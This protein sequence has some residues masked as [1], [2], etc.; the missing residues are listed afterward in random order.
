MRVGALLIALALASGCGPTV[1]ETKRPVQFQADAKPSLFF[2]LAEGTAWSYDVTDESTGGKILLVNRVEKRD[3]EV[4]TMFGGPDPLSYQDKG[5]AIVR[6]PSGSVILRGPFAVGTEW[7][8]EGG[9]ARITS[10]DATVQTGAGKLA[11][12]VA[13]EEVTDERRVVTRY[14]PEVGPVEVE[15]YARGPGGER[16]DSRGLLRSFHKAGTEFP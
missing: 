15:V 3:G 11:P 16:L 13:V 4:A 14:A 10:I 1:A 6:L 2:P 7:A 12:C 5:D 8:I 9:K